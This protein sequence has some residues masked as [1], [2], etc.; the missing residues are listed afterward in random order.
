MSSPRLALIV[1]LLLTLGGFM[2]TALSSGPEV[3]TRPTRPATVRGSGTTFSE[4]AQFLYL[5]NDL[6]ELKFN[7]SA[8]GGI[9]SVYDP[10]RSV[11]FRSDTDQPPVIFQLVL[12][13]IVNATIL[14]LGNSQSG[15]FS[16]FGS[17]DTVSGRSDLVMNYTTVGGLDINVSA[18]VQVR[19]DDPRSYWD[20]TVH[21][22]DA[23]W[24]LVEV[25]YPVVMGLSKD[26]GS[27]G[28]SDLLAVPKYDGIVYSDPYKWTQSPYDKQFRFQYPGTLSMQFLALY[29]PAVSGLFL[30]SLDPD[31]NVKEL[32]VE[33]TGPADNV[34]AGISHMLPYST[35]TVAIISYSSA[36]G[37]FH[38][39]WNQ[40]ADLYKDWALQQDWAQRGT[41]NDRLDV[42][43]WWKTP[44]PVVMIERTDGTGQDKVGIEQWSDVVATFK[45]LT[46]T[47]ITLQVKGWENNGTMTGPY[48]LPPK[49]GDTNLKTETKEVLVAGGHIMF[50]TSESLWRLQVPSLSYDGTAQ[51]NSAGRSWAVLDEAGQPVM[52]PR[53]DR[54]GMHAAVMDPT[55]KY[56]QDMQSSIS[57]GIATDVVDIQE[58][59][60]LPYDGW[61][62]CYNASH[63]HPLG[64]SALI[65]EAHQAILTKDLNAGRAVNPDFML[66]TE[67]PSELLLDKAQSYASTEDA[68][69]R[70]PY[71]DDMNTFG[72]EVQVAPIFDY[73]Y[74]QYTSSYGTAVPLG[75]LEIPTYYNSSA[76][77]LASSF[78]LGKMPS[79]KAS[80]TGTGSQKLSTLLARGSTALSTYGRNYMYLGEMLEAPP[81]AS[82]DAEIPYRVDPRDGH[83]DAGWA[84]YR[85][86]KVLSS[87]WRSADGQVAVALVNWANTSADIGLTFPSYGL[88]VQNYTLVLDRNGERSTLVPTTKLPYSMA[89]TLGPRDVVLI[90][91]LHG[92]DLAV[93]GLF[94]EP[95]STVLGGSV[96]LSVSVSNRGSAPSSTVHVFLLENGTVFDDASIGQLAP[97]TNVNLPF[98]W[99]SEGKKLGTHNLTAK[100]L[101]QADELYSSNNQISINVDVLAVPKGTVRCAVLDNETKKPLAGAFVDLF[102]L[103]NHTVLATEITGTGVDAIF[104]GVLPGTYGL[105]AVHDD[106]Y[107]G[108]LLNVVVVPDHTLVETILMDLIPVPPTTGDIMGMVLDNDTHSHLAGA[109][110]EL[111]QDNKNYTTGPDGVYEFKGLLPG[112]HSVLVTKTNYQSVNRVI[113]VTVGQVTTTDIILSAIVIPPKVGNIAG[114]VQDKATFLPL[115]DALVNL[116]GGNLEPM[117]M[118]TDLDG[119][120]RFP[121][122]PLGIYS[123]NVTTA[124]Y[125]GTDVSVNVSD[126]GDNTILVQLV[127]VPQPTPLVTL[128][129]FIRD[130]KGKPIIGAQ[131]TLVSYSPEKVTY[132]NSSGAYQFPGLH[133]GSLVVKVTVAGYRDSIKTINAT[134]EGTLWLNITMTSKATSQTDDSAWADYIM[135]G[136]ILFMLAGI[137]LMLLTGRKTEPKK[138]RPRKVR[139]PVKKKYGKS[140]KRS[141]RSEEE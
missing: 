122:L 1:V 109:T 8:K 123:L 20:I 17:N 19:D 51:F 5:Q 54:D 61:A 101:P 69:E 29:D 73:V 103:S 22:G 28:I 64:Y 106:Y 33:N 100:V 9:E 32:F 71:L 30:G 138:Q 48:Y 56:W 108:E 113:N 49:D 18:K 44:S 45:A 65:T 130:A 59:Q 85:A 128:I 14:Y 7:R 4:D 2:S 60:D 107:P 6:L 12:V 86:P 141:A 139:R 95:L 121:D 93:E 26:M 105:D 10:V 79:A 98:V 63:G 116:T 119:S 15:N 39:G 104:N 132:T 34:A 124:G 117:E 40:G 3:D 115:K 127:K 77:A 137:A 90:E 47:N 24:A 82:P 52:D 87:A 13:S 37:I 11:E 136:L 53:A 62:P 21:N 76:K 133:L 57:G 112:L 67:G 31:G 70:G 27:N 99:S 42:P 38:G 126:E 74:H 118:V 46:G 131:V 102:Y 97:D 72:E 120:F 129:G 91:A 55:T 125:Y 25:Q 140:T 50:S 36:L 88:P 96:N 23:S 66:T 84:T 75:G 80:G 68:P 92:P 78:V 83:E 89:L 16:F 41:L 35:A 94:A 134:V 81:V 135:M 110:V 43:D 114:A 111:P 58:L